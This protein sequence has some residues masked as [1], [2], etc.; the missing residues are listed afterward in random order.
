MK[1]THYL[2]PNFKS[3]ELR[4]QYQY[5]GHTAKRSQ[6]G[7]RGLHLSRKLSLITNICQLKEPPFY[8][9]ILSN[10]KIIKLKLWTQNEQN[11]RINTE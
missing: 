5:T 8:P 11:C 9:E 3:G 1:E 4:P 10:K 7:T 2:K 6:P